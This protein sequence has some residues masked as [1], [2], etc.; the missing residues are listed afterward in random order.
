MTQLLQNLKN[1]QPPKISS[2]KIFQKNLLKLKFNFKIYLSCAKKYHFKEMHHSLLEL[3]FLL[4]L[5]S[6]ILRMTNYF[7]GQPETN[8]ELPE[9]WK[10]GYSRSSTTGLVLH[11]FF[12]FCCVIKTVENWCCFFSEEVEYSNAGFSTASSCLFRVINTKEMGSPAQVYTHRVFWRETRV[13]ANSTYAA[14]VIFC[15]IYTSLY[16]AYWIHFRK[17]TNSLQFAAS[18]KES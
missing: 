6:W 18:Q 4:L 17:A 14:I 3:L 11:L 15:V 5:A 12:C 1:S 16:C 2:S 7:I 10:I 13:L 8:S 9:N